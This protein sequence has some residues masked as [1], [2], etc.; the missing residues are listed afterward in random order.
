MGLRLGTLNKSLKPLSN[1]H[2][3]ALKELGVPLACARI[4]AAHLPAMG[5]LIIY[6]SNS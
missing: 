5:L 1:K 6:F 2:S 4:S 3:L